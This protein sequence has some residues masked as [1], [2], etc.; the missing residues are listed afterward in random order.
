MSQCR[1]RNSCSNNLYRLRPGL[2]MMYLAPV[3]KDPVWKECHWLSE[4]CVH[5]GLC[6]KDQD[7]EPP[8]GKQALGIRAKRFFKRARSLRIATR[9]IAPPAHARLFGFGGASGRLGR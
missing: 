5:Q 8:N 4:N 1:T 2:G 3:L 6:R 7:P 9:R